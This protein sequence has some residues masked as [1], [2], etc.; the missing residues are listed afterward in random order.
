MSLLHRVRL[1][2]QRRL[3]VDVARYPRSD[4]L[5]RT[6]RLLDVAAVTTVLDVGANDGGFG[7]SLR[8]LG[9]RG[10]IVS[11]EPTRAAFGRLRRTTAGDGRWVAH[12]LALGD[13]DGRLE[14]NVAGNDAAS[15]SFLPML[16]QHLDASPG[17]A[18]V[19]KEQVE[20]RRLDR[21]WSEVVAA[22]DERVFL[23]LDVQGA[24]G[25]VLDGA[26]G[27]MD[28]LVGIQTELNLV[29]LYE[30]Q[31]DYRDVLDRLDDAGFTLAGVVPGFFDPRTGRTLEIDGVFLR[32]GALRGSSAS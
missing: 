17:S 30:G 25:M 14:I 11:F 29:R 32:D 7:R 26:A 19:S 5:Y 28:E 3:G 22:A 31:I 13:H 16:D 2:V 15:S 12:N 18:Y 8:R 27:I 21:M 24:E 9:Y 10:R 6:S 4:P 20:V 1:E 23:K